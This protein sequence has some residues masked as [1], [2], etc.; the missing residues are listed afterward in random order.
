MSSVVWIFV[1][2]LGYAV[3]AAATL[4]LFLGWNTVVPVFGAIERIAGTVR[5]A[6][7]RL[8]D[9]AAKLGKRDD[10]TP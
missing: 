6:Q 9:F 5:N 7:H 4:N 2:V 3:I 10:R 1:I 8:S